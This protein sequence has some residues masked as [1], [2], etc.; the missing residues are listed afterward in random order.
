MRNNFNLLK[1]NINYSS[2]P[3]YFF[4]QTDEPIIFIKSNINDFIIIKIKVT[5]E[6]IEGKL[7]EYLL[8]KKYCMKIKISVLN[9]VRLFELE[10]LHYKPQA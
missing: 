8:Y 9:I 10:L 6:L 7:N 2:Y 4:K 5:I 1:R 3:F